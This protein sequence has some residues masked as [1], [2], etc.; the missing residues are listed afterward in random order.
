M[1]EG[2][3][4]KEKAAVRGRQQSSQGTSKFSCESLWGMG[5]SAGNAQIWKQLQTRGSSS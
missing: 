2:E 5:E 1:D 4:K 3:L